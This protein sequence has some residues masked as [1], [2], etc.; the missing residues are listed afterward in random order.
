MTNDL[1]APAARLAPTEVAARLRIAMGRMVRKL[2]R[3]SDGQH[4]A[5]AISALAS[6]SRLGPLT[7]GELAEA[8]DV[9]RP[10]MTVLAA[11]LERQRL[12]ARELD[13]A[14]RRL[15]RVTL[16]AVG[17]RALQHS[18]TRRNAYLA[19]RLQTLGEA[20][21]RTLDEAAAIL[22]RLLEDR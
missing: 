6:I 20:E 9:S 4:P 17:R 13:A 2:R 14:D 12:I 19:R 18:Q 11:G 16:T 7:L 1:A 21:L 8:E 5:P 3:E 15:V 22:E 10:T